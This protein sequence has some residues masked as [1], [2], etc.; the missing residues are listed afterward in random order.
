MVN[1]TKGRRR[2]M[3]VRLKS[4][5]VVE[6]QK[7]QAAE[8]LQNLFREEDKIQDSFHVHGDI[9]YKFRYFFAS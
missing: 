2:E 3:S 6:S 8:W 1:P 4:D 7:N 9:F 5:L